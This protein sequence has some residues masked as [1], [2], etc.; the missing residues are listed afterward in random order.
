MDKLF[1]IEGENEILIKKE[2]NSII[3][4]IN[5]NKDELE[6][7]KYDLTETL[8]DDIIEDLDTYDMFLKKKIIIGLNPPFLNEKDDNFNTE[9]FEKYLKNPSENILILV[10]KKKNKRLKVVSLIE[11]YFK[12][13]KIKE[14]TLLSFIEENI[15]GYT[16]DKQTKEYFLN[17]VGKDFK[18]IEQE[19]NKL[20]SYQLDT[21]KITKDD[22][23]LIT[24]Q[25][26]EASIFDLIEAIIKK[27]KVKSYELYNHFIQN[28]TEVFQIW[29]LL[30]NQIRLIYNVK[31]LS[32]LSDFEISNQLGVKEYPVKL[33][34]SKGYSYTKKELLSLLYDL[35][36]L[37]LDIKTGRQLVDVSFISY[38]MQM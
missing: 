33:A 9:K 7:I 8:I 19:L 17:K 27:D 38:V 30:S 18:I 37:D 11:K 23:D 12:E 29:V 36:I 16:M 4:K 1:L 34:R 5:V 10:T 15:K 31:V 24:S 21:K 35:S 3:Q 14:I 28:G 22:I 26:I 2:I 25:N 32:Y 6:I 13:I 20:K